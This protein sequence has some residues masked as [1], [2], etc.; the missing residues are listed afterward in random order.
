[1][2]PKDNRVELSYRI[3]RVEMPADAKE[4]AKATNFCVRL[5]EKWDTTSH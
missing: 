3:A 1:M 5:S 4:S 2:L